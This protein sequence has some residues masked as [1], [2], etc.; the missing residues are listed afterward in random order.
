M[1][2]DTLI[3]VADLLGTFAFAAGGA[4][5]ALRAAKLDIVGMIFLGVVSAVG[6]G[7]IRDV[8]IGNIPPIAL[9]VWYYL[10]V[11]TAGSLLP[12]VLHRPN[13]LLK[14]TVQLFDSVGLSL[15]CVVGALKAMSAGL[16][17]LAAITMGAIT[18]VGGGVLRDL[19]V[20]RV[21]EVLRTGF[22]VIP[23]LVGATIVVVA[24]VVDVTSPWASLAG[25][26]AAWLLRM[27]GVWRGL[28]APS[29]PTEAAP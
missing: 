15:F 1:H 10:V 28:Q 8:L 17:P 23:A 25:G 26:L 9:D 20:K 3:L 6:G 27:L 13:R 24:G 18:A 19:M 21:P 22:Y 11:A 2:V 12:M 7:I 5:T 4:Y 16:T 29:A 14:M